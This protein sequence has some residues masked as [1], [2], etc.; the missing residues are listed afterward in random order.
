M[1]NFQLVDPR[2]WEYDLH[3]IFSAYVGYFQAHNVPWY[4]RTWG[5]MFDSFDAFLA[6]SWPAITV[7]DTWTCRPHIVTR[8]N[9]LGAFIK[10]I[11]TRFG[12]ALPVPPNIITV[13]PFES[14]SR[15]LWHISDPTT[16]R[17]LFATLPAA[18]LAAQKARVKAGE[19]GAVQALWDAR[20]RTFLAV[21]F[22]WSERNESS[23]MEFGYAAVRCAHLDSQGSWPPGPENYRSGHYITA[24]YADKLFNKYTPTNPW[25][26]AFGDSQVLSKT[27]LAQV[28]QSVI[29][30]LATPDSETTQNSL[31]LVGHGMNGILAR[32]VEMKIR[33]P[34]NVLILDTAVYERVL[35]NKGLRP[36][37]LDPKTGAA[38][39]PNTSLSLENLVRSIPFRSTS[40]SSSMPPLSLQAANASSSLL[41]IGCT[42]HNAGNDAYMT[43]VGLQALAVPNS[44]T[45]PPRVKTTGPIGSRPHH[46][47][48]IGALGHIHIP[49]PRLSVS[50]FTGMP[51]PGSTPPR[52]SPRT[53]PA[54]V[55]HS[56]SHTG[57]GAGY[58][59]VAP[60][61]A[62]RPQTS[63][64]GGGTRSATLPP[65]HS[66]DG[67][68]MRRGSNSRGED[69]A[70]E[71][72]RMRVS[73]REEK[74]L[75]ARSKSP[76]P[77]GGLAPPQTQKAR[78]FSSYNPLRDL[79]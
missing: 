18:V 44:I 2:G 28:I 77:E 24:E 8:P 78:R 45:A 29:S 65:M 22:E 13:S 69:L 20:D 79:F 38:R 14:A 11:K 47:M 51:S 6:F 70:D 43:L 63:P 9:S 49:I 1:S 15:H 48:A 36:P 3:S 30:S 46:S 41:P 39:A 56:H 76:G 54:A 7:T 52:V 33:I 53:T 50:P 34:H 21:D 75:R 66:G 37:M 64:M 12:E 55:Q 31:V 19:P 62:A 17:K 68:R 35:H 61:T 23:V 32:L 5:H 73:N 72:A 58:L 42:M 27:K 10:M 59:D 74:S 60:S 25:H 67:A 57:A 40:P 4:D 71:F 16:Y 26:Y